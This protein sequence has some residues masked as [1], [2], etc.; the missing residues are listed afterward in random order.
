MSFCDF[1]RRGKVIQR[2]LLYFCAVKLH[3]DIMALLP[4]D[5]INVGTI[6]FFQMAC[7][8][9]HSD[10]HLKQSDLWATAQRVLMRFDVILSCI[11]PCH[12]ASLI[13]VV[14]IVIDV[15][16]TEFLVFWGWLQIN[17]MHWTVRR[18]IWDVDSDE[19]VNTNLVVTAHCICFIFVFI[20]WSWKNFLHL[21][22]ELI[23]LM[24]WAGH[25]HINGYWRGWS[26]WMFVGN[27]D[28]F[29]VC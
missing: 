4:H 21:S 8:K 14:V 2:T 6:E 27:A 19:V 18:W 26:S 12:F 29:T 22:W 16:L 15:N 1:L 23:Y 24:L 13:C 3:E 7:C 20:V 9:H 28:P 17:G 10:V 25:V 11:K 5:Q